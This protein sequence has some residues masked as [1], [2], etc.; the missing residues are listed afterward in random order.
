MPNNNQ[1][2]S[3]KSTNLPKKS[4]ENYMFFQHSH[5]F[6]IVLFMIT[7]AFIALLFGDSL[8][9][10][11]EIPVTGSNQVQA[12]ATTNQYKQ[13]V[14]NIIHEFMAQ[15][16]KTDGSKDISASVTLNQLMDLKV[17]DDYKDFHLSLIL[18]F[19]QIKE[20]E[21]KADQALYEQAIFS[22]DS[23]SQTDPWFNY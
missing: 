4:I 19:N 21:A 17:A 18:A 9:E 23:L 16:V 7:I 8:K 11:G 20:S 15:P 22:L 6:L 2:N 10:N 13:S 1:T 5:Y 14:N 3:I 12:T